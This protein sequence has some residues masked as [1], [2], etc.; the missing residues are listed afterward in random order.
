MSALGPWSPRP[1]RQDISALLPSQSNQDLDI[2]SYL[3]F[4]VPST[5]PLQWS[6]HHPSPHDLSLTVQLGLIWPCCFSKLFA[7][8]LF[9]NP[10]LLFSSI[11]LFIFTLCM[12]FYVCWVSR[13]VCG[14]SCRC[15]RVEPEV[16]VRWLSRSSASFRFFETGGFPSE[17]EIHL[18]DETGWH[19][20]LVIHLSHLWVLVPSACHTGSGDWSQVLRAQPAG[21]LPCEPYLLSPTRPF[22]SPA[23]SDSK[24]QWQTAAFP[25]PP[26]PTPR[27][28]LGRLSL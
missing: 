18:F 26:P 23:A 3:Q 1:K 20:P 9:E 14:C 15:A 17:S 2:S 21:T 22:V 12:V 8:Q 7:P 16:H 4:I 28:W 6:L 11:R 13:Y 25:S 24:W 27:F 10:S 19:W 5:L